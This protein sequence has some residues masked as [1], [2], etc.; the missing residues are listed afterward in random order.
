MSLD[1]RL[2]RSACGR[3][4]TGVVVATCRT[5]SGDPAGVTV[6]SFTSVSLDPPLIL[7]CLDHGA[8]SVKVFADVE[9]FAINMLAGDQQ[10]LSHVFATSV[11]DRFAGVGYTQGHGGA[12]LLAGALCHLECEIEHRYPGG[13]HEIIVGRVVNVTIAE[14]DGRPLIYYKGEYGALA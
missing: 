11:A 9:A 12:P 3:F 10:A 7:F 13:D 2:F 5:K 1:P 4:A 14:K 8:Y 6:N